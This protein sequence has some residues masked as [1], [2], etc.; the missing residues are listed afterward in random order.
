MPSIITKISLL[1][2]SENDD[3]D[4]TLQKRF[5]TYEGLFM[6]GGGIMWGTLALVFDR[7]IQSLIPFG[8]VVLTFFNLL[9]FWKTKSFG[10]VKTFQTAI[11]LL[12][13]FAFQWTLGGFVASGGVMLW[14]LLALAAAL[15]YQSAR[16]VG[17]WLALYV[18]LTVISGVFDSSFRA[19]IHPE[20]V[21]EG[22]SIIFFVANISVISAIM[23]GLVLFVVVQKDNTMNKLVN[24]QSALIQSERMAALGQLVAGVAHEVNTPLGAIKSTAEELALNHDVVIKMG[25]TLIRALSEAE[26]AAMSALVQSANDLI[27][28]LSSREER[29]LRRD[30]TQQLEAMGLGNAR[31]HADRLVQAGVYG[32]SPELEVLIK[33]PGNQAVIEASCTFILQRRNTD[34]ILLAVDK[35]ARVVKALKTYVHKTDSDHLEATQL[36]ESM[37]T[38]LT[39]YYS[40]LKQGVEVVKVFDPIPPIPAY[41]DEL[42]QVWTNLIHN[43]IQAMDYKGT[44]TL[45]I[46]DAGAFVEV[47]I[48]DTGTGIQPEVRDKIFD[49]FFTTKP[50][51][52]G[53]GLGLDIVKQIVLKHNG[54]IRVESEPGQGATF[55]VLL[56]KQAANPEHGKQ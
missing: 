9:Y 18:L 42:N 21:A 43:A 7:E 50:L 53:T 24:T 22:L 39:I 36:A 17:F 32:I 8:Y 35:A 25:P 10:F 23:F 38:V 47:S 26:V 13:P 55:F 48:A 6:S 28:S 46:K 4:L 34:N 5:L 27:K 49:P 3:Q 45:G 11:S 19:L 37:E 14:A 33:S 2:V 12:L 44:L 15:T 41:V 31:Y 16:K 29:T 52:E 40:K 54:K 56:P 1:G 30:L 51:G 20:D